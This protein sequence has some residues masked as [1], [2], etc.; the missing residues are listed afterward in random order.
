MFL[1]LSTLQE[2]NPSSYLLKSQCS[3]LVT[4]MCSL[5]VNFLKCNYQWVQYFFLQYSKHAYL[6]FPVQCICF[7]LSWQSFSNVYGQSGRKVNSKLMGLIPALWL[8]LMRCVGFPPT[9]L[10]HAREALLNTKAMIADVNVCFPCDHVVT[11]QR[12]QSETHLWKRGYG[13]DKHIVFLLN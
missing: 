13:C 1:E 5:A 12:V 9:V 2:W 11:W 6:Y 7:L 8:F 10:K 3:A 4:F